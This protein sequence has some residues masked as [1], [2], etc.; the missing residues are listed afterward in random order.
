MIA[1]LY[2]GRG[3]DTPIRAAI[4][5]QPLVALLGLAGIAL[6]LCAA[7]YP[8]EFVA[9]RRWLNPVWVWRER[10]G[11]AALLAISACFGL[12]VLELGSRAL[13]ARDE[14]LPY[15]FSPE[16]L[17]YP[18]LY[19]AMQDYDPKARNVIVLGGSVMFGAG[20]GGTLEAELGPPWRVYNLAQNAQCSLDSLTKYKWLLDQGYRFDYVL[21]YEAINETRLN[22]APP[23]VFRADYS[24]YLFY[25]LVHVIFGEDRPV[26]RAALH[27]AL[28]F[29]ADRLITQ[30][31][32]T[33]AFGQHFV[34]IAYPRADWLP[35]GADVKTAAPYEANLIA[36]ADLATRNGAT[37]ITA[38]FAYDPRL[39]AYANGDSS[40]PGRETMLEFTKEWGLPENVHKGIVVHNK[41]L[42]SHSGD[43]RVIS[44]DAFKHSE[45]FIDPCHFTSEAESRFVQFWVEALK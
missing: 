5:E 25:R 7:I 12:L 4:L 31:R 8:Q 1:K 38:D 14:K 33:R 11:E 16:H 19:H 37:L 3:G 22:N 13:Y 40:A 44:S 36:I 26:W 32:E 15:W 2:T 28:I 6:G 35:Y 39:D 21:L 9:A 24:H 17:V 34:N 23:E 43:F 30:L 27:S 42:H 41:I 18:P 20:R 29:R 10:K 45:N